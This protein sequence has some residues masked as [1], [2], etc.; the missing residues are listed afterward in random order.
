MARGN[1]GRIW[2]IKETD[3]I[4]FS[5]NKEQ[6]SE[7]KALNK[8]LIYVTTVTQLSLF[9][10]LVANKEHCQKTLKALD[11]LRPIGFID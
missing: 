2:Q 10:G 8:I 4:A 9:T 3:Q 6:L 5:Y 1:P 7:F 11:K